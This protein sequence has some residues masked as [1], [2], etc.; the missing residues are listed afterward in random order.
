MQR[1]VEQLNDLERIIEE[2]IVAQRHWAGIFL[3]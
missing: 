1:I 2:A 3:E